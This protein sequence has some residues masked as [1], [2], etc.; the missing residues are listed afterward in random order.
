VVL[1]VD[2]YDVVFTAGAEELLKTFNRF[3]ARIL[4]SAEDACWPDRSLEVGL[5]KTLIF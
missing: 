2:G 4:F 1:F 5:I 3:E